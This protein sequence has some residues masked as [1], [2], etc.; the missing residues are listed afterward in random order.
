MLPEGEDH[1]ILCTAPAE[2][3][4]GI[5]WRTGDG[6]TRA[7]KCKPSASILILYATT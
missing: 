5:N 3:H 2:D 1:S 4:Y 6:E 7:L